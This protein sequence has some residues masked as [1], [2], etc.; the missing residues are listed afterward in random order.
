M[1]YVLI[2]TYATG[3][4]HIKEKIGW[5]PKVDKLILFA[6]DD[7]VMTW[8]QNVGKYEKEIH[9]IKGFYFIK[10]RK[11]GKTHWED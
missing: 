6:N 4:C 11:S 2:K 7:K 9:F 3:M 5:F 10:K 1:K 8:R